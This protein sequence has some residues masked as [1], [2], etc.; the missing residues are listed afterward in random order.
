MVYVSP[1]E[2]LTAALAALAVVLLIGAALVVGLSNAPRMV[3]AINSAFVAVELPKPA[4]YPRTKTRSTH[5]LRTDKAK[6]PPAPRNLRNRAAA[7]VAPTL[8]PLI[9]PPPTPTA[10]QAGTGAATQSGAADLLGLGQ[11][12]GGVGAGTG[13]GGDGLRDGDGISE[14]P[15]EQIR[16]HLDYSDMPRAMREAG[17]EAAVGVRYVVDTDGRVTSCA[18]TKLSGSPELDRI[19]CVLI[20]KRFRFRPSYDATGQPVQAVIVETHRWT[21]DRGLDDPSRH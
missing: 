4:L 6:R 9:V 5:L 15:P 12:A 10:R 1:S 19:T 3:A 17:L 13:G 11:G 14:T 18:V 20:E 16:G 8:A 2:R 7:I 21:T